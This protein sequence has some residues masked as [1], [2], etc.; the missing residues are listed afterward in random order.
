MVRWEIT[1]AVVGLLVVYGV[2]R[3]LSIG[4]RPKDYPP[5]PPTL[6]LLGNIHQVSEDCL[7]NVP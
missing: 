5:G 1:A 7:S 2:T 3:L 6:P 4:H